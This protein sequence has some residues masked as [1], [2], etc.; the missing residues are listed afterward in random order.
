[1]VRFFEMPRATVDTTA[2]EGEPCRLAGLPAWG[3]TL[4]DDVRRVR[5][6]VVDHGRTVLHVSH[7]APPCDDPAEDARVDVLLDG[8]RLHASA[9]PIVERL[10]RRLT[11]DPDVADAWVWSAQQPL[12]ITSPVRGF[13]VGL[14]R[15]VRAVDVAPERADALLAEEVRRICNLGVLGAHPPP[16]ARVRDSLLP[17]VRLSVVSEAACSEATRAGSRSGTVC[18]EGLLRRLFAPGLF[19][20]Y[21][22]DV[23][24]AFH[25][26]TPARCATW[27]VSAAELEAAALNNLER[28]LE[29]DRFDVVEAPGGRLL[30][31]EDG[32]GLASSRLLLAPMRAHLTAVL[33]PRWHVA[34]PNAGTIIAFSAGFTDWMTFL[35]E[36]VW[37]AHLNQ[38]IPLTPQIYAHEGGGLFVPVEPS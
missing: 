37:D 34:I 6:W 27:G 5:R 13:E 21:A 24:G 12:I 17:L 1:M 14:E 30:V 28:L 29:G 26:I 15:L 10:L 3:R 20:Y 32:F 19:V 33:G 16:F 25:F 7:E 2:F 23:P 35:G 8:L 11:D 18:G 22:V 4:R 9:H 38:P 31:L 36:D